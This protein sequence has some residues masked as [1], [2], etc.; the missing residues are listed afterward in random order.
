MA[1]KTSARTH[2]REQSIIA[3][4]AGYIAQNK[5][6]PNCATSGAYCDTDHINALLDEMYSDRNV[7]FEAKQELWKRSEQLVATH[8]EA[9][10]ALA[11][12]L[13][14]KDWHPQA[15][16]ERRWSPQWPA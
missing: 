12:A 1:R 8:W 13:W 5:F 6:Y 14:A 10:E 3:T 16:L 4:N 11:K 15:P 7:W 9:I 2:L